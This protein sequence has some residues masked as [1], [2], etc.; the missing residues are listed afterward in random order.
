MQVQ[1]LQQL[2]GGV[3]PSLQAEVSKAE[4]TLKDVLVQRQQVL[5]LE[6][7]AKQGGPAV[8]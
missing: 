6:Q 1:L 7:Q 3:G 5:K 2:R 4:A 8:W